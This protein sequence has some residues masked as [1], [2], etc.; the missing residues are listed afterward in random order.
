HECSGTPP[1]PF[2]RQQEANLPLEHNSQNS[3]ALPSREAKT[4]GTISVLDDQ[5]QAYF[6]ILEEERRAAE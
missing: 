2:P 3:Q 1:P 6:N 5:Y 4:T